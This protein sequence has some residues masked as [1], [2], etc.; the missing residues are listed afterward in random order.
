MIRALNTFPNVQSGLDRPSLELQLAADCAFQKLKQYYTRAIQP[1]YAI[2][3]ALDPR[4]R[5]SWWGSRGWPSTWIQ[6]AK[7][8]VIREWE[9]HYKPDDPVDQQSSNF[10]DEYEDYVL[11]V[12]ETDAL[13]AYLDEKIVAVRDVLQFW[14]G[15]EQAAG[16]QQ[17]EDPDPLFRMARRYMAIPASSVPSERCFSRA[18]LFVPNERNRLG[19]ESLMESVL[20]DSWQ[21]FLAGDDG[22]MR[23]VREEVAKND[24]DNGRLTVVVEEDVEEEK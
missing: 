16:R 1:V 7:D 14:R 20:L 2:S 10:D 22:D 19:P 8:Q 21:R 23:D 4:C 9:D 18:K 6:T 17:G 24:E 3:L 12:Q 5:F 11:E 15:R 13:Q